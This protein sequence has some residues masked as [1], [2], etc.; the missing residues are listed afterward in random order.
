MSIKVQALIGDTPRA[1]EYGNA[2]TRENIAGRERIW[3]GAD[4][5]QDEYVMRLAATLREP[6]QLLYIL[7]TTRT[8]APLGRY[9]SP[10]F[11]FDNVRRFFEQFGRFLAE[12]SRHDIWIRS[13]ADDATIVLDRHNLIFAYG[14]LDVFE[15]ELVAAGLRRG[16]PSEIPD[17]HVHHY[18]AEWD[19]AE[20]AILKALDWTVLPLREQD[21]Q[22]QG[23]PAS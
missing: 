12:D 19:D 7:H 4:N 6:F 22:Y 3:I 17:P 13:H 15:S 9:E 18:H 8:G 2:F 21:I 16:T 5:E 10:E 23:P 20:R 11:A 14:P 1:F